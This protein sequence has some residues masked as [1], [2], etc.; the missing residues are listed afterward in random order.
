MVIKKTDRTDVDDIDKYSIRLKLLD[1]S[2]NED[3]DTLLNLH[4]TIGSAIAKIIDKK[5]NQ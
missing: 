3:V 2:M 1:I 5:L 4:A